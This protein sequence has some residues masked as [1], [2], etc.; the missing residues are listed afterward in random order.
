M[1]PWYMSIGMTYDEYWNGEGEMCEDYRHAHEYRQ[2][3]QNKMMWIQGLYIHD[4]FA[5]VLSNAFSKRGSTPK[6]YTEAPYPINSKMVKDEKDRKAKEAMARIL[7]M[8]KRNIRNQNK[9]KGN[10]E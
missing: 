7:G 1:A 5:V 8:M 2:I 6:R 9:S 10:G 4:A 3:E